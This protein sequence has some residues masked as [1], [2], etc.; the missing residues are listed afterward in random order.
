MLVDELSAIRTSRCALQRW[1]ELIGAA[2]TKSM[3]CQVMNSNIINNEKEFLE[4]G[5]VN[6]MVTYRMEKQ[7]TPACPH[8][9]GNG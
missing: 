6:L 4:L 2:F 8:R 7:R 9:C 1:E 5:G 3:P